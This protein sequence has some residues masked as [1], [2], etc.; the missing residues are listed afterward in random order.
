MDLYDTKSR[1]AEA[2]VESIFRRARYHVLPIRGG[3]VLR[4]GQEDFSPNFAI[5]KGETATPELIVEVKYRPSIEQFIALEN[6]RRDSSIFA[7]ARRQWPSLQF[8]LVTDQPADGRS[9]FQVLGSENGSGHVTT[10]LVDVPAL[11]IF[12]HNVEDHERLLLRLVSLLR[13]R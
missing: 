8:V 10:D 6:Q 13:G 5:G 12:R 3:P 1:I 2:F 4:I 7:L 9:C 11:G